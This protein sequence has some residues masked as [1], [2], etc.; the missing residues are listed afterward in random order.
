MNDSNPYEVT[1]DHSD[2]PL[3]PDESSA[4]APPKQIGRYRI[5]RLL[6][7]GG[8]GLVYLA[9]DDSLD[10]SVAVKVPHAKLLSHPDDAKEYLAEAR[11][12][13]NLDHP[14]IVP[15]HDVGTTED[16]PCYVVSKYVEGT[17]LYARLKESRL[18]YIESSQLVA[19]IAEALHYAH[20]QGVVHRDVK[21]GNILIDSEG[22][23]Y[24]VDFGLALRDENIGKGLKYAGTPAYMSPEQA[25]GEGH[26]VD[27]RSDIFSLGVVFYHLLVG[28]R[29]FRGDT[30]AELLEQVTT[31]EPR[32][33][34]QYDERL[35]RELE[36]ICHKAMAKRASERYSSAH[37]LAED[38]RLFLAEQTAYHSTTLP[39]AN[40]SITGESFTPD[41]E[42]MDSAA[43]T[44][45]SVGSSVT[46][47]QPIKIVPKGLRSF[48][49]HDADFFVEL[50][51]GPRDRRGLPD[52]LRFWKTRIEE[53]DS[54]DTFAV[55]LIYGPSG[56]GKSSFVKAGLV[57]QLCN[58]VIP[59]YI[60][61]TPDETETRL[62]H[63]LRK[64]CPALEDNLTLKETLAAL[65]RGQ[66]IPVGKKVLIVL[67]QFEQWLH[68]KRT[69]E[70]A[71]LVQA[72]R[73]C[74]GGRVQCIVMVRDDFWMAVTRFLRDLE[75]RLLED[76]NL[77][78][79][80]LF[81][82]RHARK[83]L[84]AFGR[85][86]GALP[87]DTG[88]TSPE[89]KEFL[90]QAIA[91]LAEE[92][93]VICV[94]L[95]LFA[96]MM[97]GKSW[98]PATLKAVGGTKGIGET[99]LEET[100]NSSSASPEHRYH[101]K[102]ARAVLKALLPDSG[103]DI[104]GQM[105][106]Y[107]ELLESSGYASRPRDFDDLIRI[108]DREIRLITPTDPEGARADEDSGSKIDATQK[109]FQLTHDY[110][111]HSLRTWLTRKQKETRRGRAELRLVERA[112]AWNAKPENR[113]LPSW[114][115][116]ASIQLF[117]DRKKWTSAQRTMMSKAGVLHGL[118]SLLAIA[119]VFGIAAGGFALNAAANKRQRSAEARRLVAGLAQAETSQ[120]ANI[121]EDL[122]DF[123][124]LASDD[125]N[126]AYANSPDDSNTKLHAALAIL[127]QDETVLP[128]LKERLQRIPASQFAPVLK[129]LSEHKASFAEDYWGI[130]TDAQEKPDRRFH[131]AC[132]LATFSPNDSRWQDQE[133]ADFVASHLVEVLPSELLPWRSAL[134][135]VK[136]RLTDALASIYRSDDSGE[137][138]QAFATDTLGDYL[139]DD[140]ESLFD[141]LVDADARQFRVVFDR[142]DAHRQRA[143]ELGII[144]LSK[145]AS[146]EDE[147]ETVAM[148][149]ANAAIMFLRMESPD[150]VWPLLKHSPDPRVRSL[151]VNHL[152]LFGGEPEV[153]LSRYESETDISIKRALL[154]CL[155]G[156]DASRL[157]EAKRESVLQLVSDVYR[158]S[159][160]PGLHAAARW[161]LV[162]WGQ[163]DQAN[164]ID[165]E[166]QT[167]ETQNLW[168]I[169]GRGQT[170]VVIDAGEFQMGS[171][172]S[173]ELPDQYPLQ[174]L[175]RIN[176]RYAIAATEVTKSQWRDFSNDR[177]V[178]QADSDAIAD[179]IR[180]DDS[181]MGGV[182]WYE[183]T[184]YCNWLSDQEGIAS[185]QW[186]YEAA[187]EDKFGPGMKAKDDFLKLTGYRLPTGSEWEFACRAGATTTRYF[188]E[189]PTLLHEYAWYAP[190]AD[191]RSWPVAH[192]KPNDFGLFDIQGNVW[193]WCYDADGDYP[194]IVNREYDDAPATA[195]ITPTGHRIIRGGGF[196]N[197]AG[198]LTSSYR[199][200]Y[201]P[202]YRSSLTGFR[203][204]RTY[205]AE[206]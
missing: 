62:L 122:N 117:T 135:P 31:Y 91:G 27:G 155:G 140:P 136:H 156:F 15:V 112:A 195:P 106:S 76:Q 154:L 149:Q 174:H 100:F 180:T 80:D 97:K 170:F 152:S 49:A 75:I 192:L 42:P 77:A 191:N 203:P 144:E 119:V 54:D 110:L 79:V 160:D 50:L 56:C 104:K 189:S 161:L 186:C 2:S 63:G 33:L 65:R 86:F 124:E 21:P 164:S 60:E 38:L 46:D 114:G 130:S 93:K 120:V 3:P 18:P 107:D 158:N 190:N 146:S 178:V 68:A 61:A 10:R 177:R 87:D 5:Q 131:A 88:K 151:V 163:D 41:S 48:D 204:A 81:P 187:D 181:P 166:L 13:A 1:R 201:L 115:E 173:I 20:K 34:R 179:N 118:R 162:R 74:D 199:L 94:R 16:F 69:E 123:R 57:P 183:A 24:V 141:L 70:N 95:A 14:N 40:L 172:K 150:S 23:P 35:P 67:D 19:T 205:V 83:V 111:V 168:Y 92:G 198:Y 25:R 176:R 89:Q 167:E 29:P 108:L 7:K 116:F 132:A 101:Q 85:A 169:N 134:R 4:G 99:F 102:A 59:V 109:Y 125:L 45:D 39:G 145:E 171:P 202:D 127:P 197:F 182:T 12:V 84:A 52:G 157:A 206:E 11:T 175:K 138:I 121:I 148:R 143:I 165:E 17:S 129:L 105:K 113:H 9:H 47:S 188:G 137:Q 128:F 133:F 66:G 58:N 8:F 43:S 153:I 103:A 37:D 28:R 36:R 73:Q 196:M 51:P 193:E 26:R 194:V 139:A 185:D 82:E 147:K 200:S 64:S 98:T 44:V 32:P 55:G 71:D 142:L 53:T 159:P 126:F 22:K 6:G 90:K 184:Q 96:E 72:L 78:A 30:E